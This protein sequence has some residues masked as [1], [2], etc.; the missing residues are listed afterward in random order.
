MPAVRPDIQTEQTSDSTRSAMQGAKAFKCH[1][2][3]SAKSMIIEAQR[4]WRFELNLL[5]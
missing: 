4:G 2:D 1:H 3:L 5:S